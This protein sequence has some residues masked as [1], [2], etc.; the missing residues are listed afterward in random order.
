MKRGGQEASWEPNREKEREREIQR[1]IEKERRR[2]KKS[3]VTPR[4]ELGWLTAFP[5]PFFGH[6]HRA[7]T[8]A[9]DSL[10]HDIYM[11][12]YVHI[13]LYI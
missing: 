11:H 1:E 12:G 3:E 8:Y 6:L 7:L 9:H 2:G 5:T 4:S 13:C 10:S